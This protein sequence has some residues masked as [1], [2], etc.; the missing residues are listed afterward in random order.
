MSARRFNVDPPIYRRRMDFFWSDSEF[1]TSRA[2]R[3]LDWAPAG[4]SLAEGV[5]RTSEDYRRTAPAWRRCGTGRMI[6][7]V[8]APA[9]P[10]LAEEAGDDA[11]R[12]S[13]T[14]RRRRA[15]CCLE[16]GCGTGLTSLLPPAAGRHLGELP[17]SSGITSGP[18]G[19]WSA[20]GCSR[21]SDRTIPF[22]TASF[23]LV[24]ADQ[25]P[26]AHQG[27]RDLLRRD[28]PGAQAGR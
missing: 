23:D 24:A 27:R 17:T 19:S 1:D 15:G 18:R 3:V 12:C 10:P 21:S 5:R 11:R 26:R 16:L 25:L 6:R 14:C 8:A 4:R 7:A 13:T 28:G 22:R 20:I 9:L 2:R